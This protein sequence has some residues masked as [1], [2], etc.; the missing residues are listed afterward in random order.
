MNQPPSVPDDRH[1]VGNGLSLALRIAWI[2]L[3][4]VAVVAVYRGD[5]KFF[6][7]GF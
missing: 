7:Q 4:L 1:A 2:A 3:R 5:M 6:Y